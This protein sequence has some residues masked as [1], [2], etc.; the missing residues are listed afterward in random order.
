MKTTISIFFDDGGVFN[1]NEIRTQQWLELIA[2]FF[3]P[4]YG[5]TRTQWKAANKETKVEPLVT[6]VAV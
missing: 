2:D 4:R 5:G 3:I 6:K 1:D